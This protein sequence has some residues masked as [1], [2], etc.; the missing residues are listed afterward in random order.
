MNYACCSTCVRHLPRVARSSRTST[1]SHTSTASANGRL[2][3]QFDTLVVSA[4]LFA[5]KKGTR[6]LRSVVLKPVDMLNSGS[7]KKDA[8]KRAKGGGFQSN[9]CC[10]VAIS[11]TPDPGVRGS[12]AHYQVGDAL[13]R[14]EAGSGNQYRVR[15][16]VR[17]PTLYWLKQH[18][19]RVPLGTPER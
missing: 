12:E 5:A 8:E 1:S 2:L 19:V 18:S 17:R 10:W 7:G 15:I 11:D 6:R 9:F 16:P 3:S 4:L 14:P 13:R